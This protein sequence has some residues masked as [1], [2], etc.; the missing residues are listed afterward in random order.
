MRTRR[1]A[2][3]SASSSI[4]RGFELEA[5]A[6]TLAEIED[7]AASFDPLKRRWPTRTSARSI[8]AW[9]SW[10]GTAWGAFSARRGPRE[11]G[12][13]PAAP[14][15][16]EDLGGRHGRRTDGA[17]RRDRGG[18]R[19]R[20]LRD[21]ADG[22]EVRSAKHDASWRR[23]AIGD[24]LRLAGAASLPPATWPRAAVQSS[25]SFRVRGSANSSARRRAASSPM[26]RRR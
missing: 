17:L 22:R 16:R 15:P 3:G 1:G 13:G 23:A 9:F 26:F 8:N 12:A 18:R 24:A 19:R 2:C 20:G 5:G 14:R 7:R 25:T 10:A 21:R 4:G 11:R 6:V